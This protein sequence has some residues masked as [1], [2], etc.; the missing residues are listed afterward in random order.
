[1]EEG[2][3]LLDRIKN[4]GTLPMIT[5]CCPGWVKFC[6]TFSPK[7]LDHLSS[8]KSPQQ[9]F[10]AVIKT[11]YAEKAGVDPKDI[12]SISIMPCT[13]KKFEC[14][15]PEFHDSG[16]QDVD[17]S[18]TVVELAN[19][20][21]AAGINFKELEETP[22]DTP[23]GLGSGAGEIFGAT[24]GVMEAALRTVY[25]VITGKELPRLDFTEVRGVE[26]LKEAVIDIDGL[27]VKVAVVHSLSNAREMLRKVRAGKA[28]Y[29]FIEVMACP[30]G[31]VGGGGTPVRSWKKVKARLDAAYEL[32]KQLPIRKS[33]ENPAI[34]E[35]YAEFLGEPLSEKAHHLLH[36][37]YISRRDLLS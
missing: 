14:L 19:M 23:F 37:S 6:E 29:H 22:F 32:D 11:Y 13:A 26:G 25:E 21:K 8:A 34:K 15:R 33:H 2:Y 3:E 30:G 16:Y 4:G 31:C 20:I 1:M 5:S 10:G 27:E 7:E 36:T 24:G 28:D 17:I 12:C 35:I 18:L 9:M